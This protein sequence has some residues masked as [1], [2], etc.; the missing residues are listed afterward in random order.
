M[1][2]TYRAKKAYVMHGAGTYITSEKVFTMSPAFSLICLY[3]CSN[4][5]TKK[6]IER[7]PKRE[8]SKSCENPELGYLEVLRNDVGWKKASQV[9]TITFLFC[10]SRSFVVPGIS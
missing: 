6:D 10:E 3:K 5:R 9:V 8:K 1:R 4:G 2:S 7:R